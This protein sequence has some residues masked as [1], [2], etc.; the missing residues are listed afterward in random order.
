MI[1]IIMDEHL[2]DL[3]EVRIWNIKLNLL[4]V[5]EIVA[6]VTQWVDEGKRNIHL[7]GVSADVAALAQNNELLREAILSSDI[8]NVDSFI[9]TYLL[10]RKGYPIKERVPCPD[11]MEGFFRYANEKK[12]KVYFLGAKATTLE[13]LVPI[14]K[15]DYPNLII[16]GTQ[17]G[18]YTEAEEESIADRISS[19]SPDFLFIAMP[20]PKKELFIK[21]YKNRINVGVFYGIG[22]AF[23]ARTGEV[24]RPPHFLRGNGL[25]GILRVL[26]RPRVYAKRLPML[27]RFYKYAIHDNGEGK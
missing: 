19:V 8:V 9:P 4:T 10:K 13:L 26:K 2:M 21:T 18:Y 25:E 17:D 6:I 22:G 14:I 27:Y 5:D 1:D 12:K 7:T 15:K 11:I 16:V 20:T 24:K 3:K 23:E